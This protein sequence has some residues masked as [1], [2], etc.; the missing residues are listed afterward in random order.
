MEKPHQPVTQVVHGGRTT[1]DIDARPIL[2]PV[3]PGRLKLYLLREE[4]RE[5]VRLDAIFLLIN[6]T[7]V[8]EVEETRQ[9]ESLKCQQKEV[10]GGGGAEVRLRKSTVDVSLRGLGRR[11]TLFQG[12]CG[13]YPTP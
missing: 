5:V 9:G 13:H 3:F 2:E 12:P 4:E 8:V 11:V 7:F 10:R 6:L 1:W